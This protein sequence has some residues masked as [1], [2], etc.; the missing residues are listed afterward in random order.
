MPKK[1][2]LITGCSTGIGRLAALTFQRKG[3]N[4][5]ATMRSPER[6]TELSGLDSVTVKRLDVTGPESVASA[7]DSTVEQ[8]GTIDV[9]VNNAGAAVAGFSNRR[10]T[11]GPRSV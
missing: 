10:A 5:V 3:W 4:V 1:T 11:R 6:E 7:V 8:F 2:V 9:L